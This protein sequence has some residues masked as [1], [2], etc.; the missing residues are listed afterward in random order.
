MVVTVE[1][2]S[3]L[4]KL[5]N[6]KVAVTDYC[7]ITQER[8][9]TFAEATEDRQWIHVDAERARVDS[10]YRA[11]VA[12][13]FLTLSLFSAF[14]TG[15]VKLKGVKMGINCGLNYVRFLAPI[16]VGAQIRAHITLKALQETADGVQVT[17]ELMIE[18]KNATRPAANGEWIVRYFL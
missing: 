10:P 7:E 15:A 2:I 17:W 3:E 18:I 11:T 13:G 14:L 5:L 8:I 12:H 6:Q 4:K 16:S 9:N 1:N